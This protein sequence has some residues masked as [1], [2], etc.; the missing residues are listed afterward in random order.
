[1]PQLIQYIDYLEISAKRLEAF[2]TQ[3]LLITEMRSGQYK[4]QFQN[5]N[6]GLMLKRVV[7]NM[8]EA[9]RS[10]SVN[11]IFDEQLYLV[12]LHADAV[13]LEICVEKLIDNA[14]RFSPVGGCVRVDCNSD[15][16]IVKIVV[17]DDGPGFS[18]KALKN[19]FSIFGIGNRHEDNS[20]GLNLA[21]VKQ[22]VDC[23]KGT[24]SVINLPDKGAEVTLVLP[25]AIDFH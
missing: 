25:Q 8:E 3:A 17:A 11:V 16:M 2:S 5:M 7:A 21:I 15:D 20:F 19:L 12:F 9:L 6:L 14:V 23:H 1:M 22:I 13:L 24:V 4:T 18:D 10:K